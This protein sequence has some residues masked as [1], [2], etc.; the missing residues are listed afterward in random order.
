M[1]VLPQILNGSS[2]LDARQTINNVLTGALAQSQGAALPLVVQSIITPA[3]WLASWGPTQWSP[4][5]V[6][7]NYALAAPYA[8]VG[9]SSGAIFDLFSTTRSAPSNTY[10]ISPTGNDSTGSGT[11]GSPWASDGKAITIGNATGLPFKVI[12]AA[13]TYYR[14]TITQPTVDCA[15]IAS[16]GRVVVTTADSAVSWAPDGTQTNTYSVTLANVNKILDLLNIDIY[17]KFVE[18]PFVTTPAICNRTPNSWSYSGGVAYINRGDGA[19]ATVT[20][21]RLLRS[22]AANFSVT[23]PISMYF[24]GVEAGSGF[25]F[26]GGQL[27]AFL[28]APT[29]VPGTFKAV[30][31]DST[32]FRYAG[33]VN[34]GGTAQQANGAGI[35]SV[36]G[37]ALFFNCDAS[38]NFADGFNVHNVTASGANVNWGTINCTGFDN[39]RP[40]AQS[41]N[42]WTQH[43]NCTGFDFCGIFESNHG[44]TMRP[45]NITLSWWVASQ[46]RY[47]RGD[48]IFGGAIPPTA[49]YLNDTAQAWMDNVV[50]IMGAGQVSVRLSSGTQLHLRNMP[51]LRIAIQGTG[52]V[53][54]Y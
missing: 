41:C 15:F 4:T 26:E 53:D 10:Y 25:D 18:I 28:Y 1:A 32:T 34:G 16:A 3:T 45:I 7:V 14:S 6:T 31:H 27:A 30:V 38:G 44:G 33:G 22:T 11:Q 43:E 9:L 8:S 13:G 17:G 46:P 40:P 49:I 48:V 35:N 50:P 36:N 29:T 20:N 21:T 37:I 47:D 42:G 54:T 19:A 5:A 24:G 23:N 52:T 12:Q 2:G 39:G 51:P